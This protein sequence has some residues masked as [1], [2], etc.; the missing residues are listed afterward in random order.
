MR[1]AG[2]F[3]KERGLFRAILGAATQ[4]WATASLAS[5]EGPMGCLTACAEGGEC[6]AWPPFI[7]LTLGRTD[8]FQ[9]SYSSSLQGQC[10]Q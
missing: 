5:G 3:I 10:F 9:G 1:K 4:G 8:G 2:S 6:V 7:K